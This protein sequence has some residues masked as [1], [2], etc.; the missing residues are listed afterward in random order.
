MAIKFV[1]P[2]A[3]P[4]DIQGEI[5]VSGSFERK[6]MDKETLDEISKSL[7]IIEKVEYAIDEPLPDPK[8]S[9]EMMVR[10]AEIS[11]APRDWNFF[12]SL[13]KDK[14]TLLVK[15]IY[16]NGL[17]NPVTL[18]EQKDGRYMM[19]SGHNRDNAYDILFQITGNKKYQQIPAKIY[20][21]DDIDETEAR[22]I[23]IIS[24]I[25][26]RAKESHRMMMKSVIELTKLE[27]KRAM[28][29]AGIHVNHVIA[30]R[31]GISESKV[32]F[33]QKLEDLNDTLLDAFSAGEITRAAAYTFSL[34]P[35]DIQDLIVDIHAYDLPKAKLM[36]LKKARTTYEAMKIIEGNVKEE[37]KII[38]TMESPI[39]RPRGCTTLPLF[40]PKEEKNLV[41]SI[42]E[43]AIQSDDRVSQNMKEIIKKMF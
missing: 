17:L 10:R 43:N 30:N 26:Q 23:I 7:E 6:H 36:K 13:D 1:D 28:Y 4:E 31:M 21:H 38:Y 24:N 3:N 41:K 16:E 20:K 15:S 34:L 14:M 42:I 39:R 22:R 19:L 18:W 25:A 32:L 40:V 35:G 9:D 29:G 33:Y 5:G 27:R 8:L 11:H 12:D 2:N 37:T